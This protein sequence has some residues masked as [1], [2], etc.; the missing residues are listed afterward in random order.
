MSDVHVIRR[1]LRWDLTSSTFSSRAAVAEV[2]VR[3]DE[4]TRVP[5]VVSRW[6]ALTTGISLKIAKNGFS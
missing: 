3:L 2:K 5:D 4:T 6:R 1:A